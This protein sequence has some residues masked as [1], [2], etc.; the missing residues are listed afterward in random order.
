MR[1]LPAYILIFFCLAELSRCCVC[2][3]AQSLKWL[4]MSEPARLDKALISIETIY[5]HQD[6]NH[7]AAK[8]LCHNSSLVTT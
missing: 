7:D 1:S 5:P 4:T 8:K 2:V 3:I 6:S